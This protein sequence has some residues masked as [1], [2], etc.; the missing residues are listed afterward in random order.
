MGSRGS[1]WWLQATPDFYVVLWIQAHILIGTEQALYWLSCLPS[2][3]TSHFDELSTVTPAKEYISETQSPAGVVGITYFIS[4]VALGCELP[5]SQLGSYISS[6]IWKLDAAAPSFRA[7]KN[8][9]CVAILGFSTLCTNFRRHFQWLFSEQPLGPYYWDSRFNSS[10][11]YWPW[12]SG[13]Y[14]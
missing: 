9:L 7:A 6:I 11:C 12:D 5:G 14:I 13:N 10:N 4:A 1:A 3:L 8:V 2:P